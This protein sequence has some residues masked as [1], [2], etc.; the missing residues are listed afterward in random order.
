MS[1]RILAAKPLAAHVRRV[2]D[3]MPHES[4]EQAL[5]EVIRA[6]A[7]PLYHPVGTCRMGSDAKSVVS[8]SL[9]VR[10][11]EGLAVADL[12]IMPRHIS[13]NTHAAALMIGERAAEL[14]GS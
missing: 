5:D 8:P 11:V 6:A 13:G 10:G 14:F 4:D 9:R 12:S 3:S 1:T 2:L 7:G